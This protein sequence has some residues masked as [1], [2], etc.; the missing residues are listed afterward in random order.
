MKTATDT[1]ILQGL[2]SEPKTIPSRYFY[3]EVGDTLFQE[4][5]KLPEYYLT[6]AEFEILSEQSEAII[7]AANLSKDDLFE[8]VELGAGDGIKTR[9]LLSYLLESGYNCTYTPIDISSNVL[10]DL[11]NNMRDLKDLKINGIAGDYFDVLEQLKTSDVPKLILF[12]GSN[13]GNYEDAT[14]TTFLAKIA[15]TMK[16]GDALLLGLD[17]KKNSERILNAYNDS[18]GVTRDF[19]LNLLTRLNRELGA[20]FQCDQFE[21]APEYDP[22][23]KAISYLKS[24]IDQTVHFSE[25]GHQIEF[26]KGEKI[27]TE[28]SRKYDDATLIKILEGGLKIQEKFMDTQG[29]FADYLLI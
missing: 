2:L 12:L 19:N 14:A 29:D 27:R 1:S 20:N 22:E 24:R 21:H 4:I 13:L 26:R 11:E 18:A 5:M 6:R 8:V 15:A 25:T 9:Q 16:K 10:R 17:L 28:V 23:G 7:E 3:D